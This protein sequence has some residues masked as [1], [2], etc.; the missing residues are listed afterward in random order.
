MKSICFSVVLL[1]SMISFFGTREVLAFPL[2]LNTFT[3]NPTSAVSIASDGYSATFYEDLVTLTNP[4]SLE[5]VLFIPL[6]ALSISFDYALT[7]AQDNEDYFD[8][9]LFDTTT[10]VFETGGFE[11]SDSGSLVYDVTS[12]QGG[13][14]PIIFHLMSGWNND[15][16]FESYLTVS[17][18]VMT[19]V[20]EPATL[21]LIGS[22]VLTLLGLNRR[23]SREE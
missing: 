20:P 16:G 21:I 5:T 19:P 1:C 9:Y 3:P 2:D 13:T 7:V 23:R 11:N 17:N 14:V 18:V 8:F 10:P 6:D 12:F 15:A 4:V 22:G